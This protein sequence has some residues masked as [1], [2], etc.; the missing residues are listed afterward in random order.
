MLAFTDYTLLANAAKS[1][2]GEFLTK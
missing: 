2:L 1:A